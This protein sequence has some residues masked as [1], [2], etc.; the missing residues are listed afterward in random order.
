MI[1]AIAAAI[2]FPDYPRPVH[3]DVPYLDRCGFR[4]SYFDYRGHRTRALLNFCFAGLRLPS[5]PTFCFFLESSR[6]A[7]P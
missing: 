4:R 3:L 1:L 2:L 7:L 6:F 5:L